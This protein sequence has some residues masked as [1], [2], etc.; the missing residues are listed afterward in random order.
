VAEA[1]RVLR[2]GGRYVAFEHVGS[3]VLPVRAVQR[4]LDPLSVRFAGDHL[5][6]EP[7]EYL[8][9][10]GFE[11]DLLERSKWGIVERVIA[12]KPD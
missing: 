1:H 6:R 10:A 8:R 5:V 7:L 11:I 2:P 3:P 4:A 12:R 9:Q